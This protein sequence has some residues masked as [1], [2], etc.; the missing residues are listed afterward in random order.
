MKHLIW[1]MGVLCAILSSCTSDEPISE[2]TGPWE[3]IYSEQFHG[4]HNSSDD[5]KEWFEEHYDFWYSARFASYSGNPTQI[6]Y[7]SNGDY[8]ELE[9]YSKYY[10]G[11][12]E[13]IEIIDK[14][15][16]STIKQ[17]IEAF[18]S[19]TITKDDEHKYDN[20]NA[21]YRKIDK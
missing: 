8:I 4:I 20:F 12:I 13:W 18:E 21:Q 6:W 10:N 7:A 15:S 3:I 2:Y 11:D 5:F 9:D 17:K 16:E 14:A 19:F 1:I